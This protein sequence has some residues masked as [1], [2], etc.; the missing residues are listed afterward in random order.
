LLWVVY[1]ETKTVEIYAP[2]QPMR[3]VGVD[4]VLDGG[5]VLPGFK[6]AV[7]EIFPASE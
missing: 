7:A 3:W 4:G 6:L 2:G 5:D 1:P